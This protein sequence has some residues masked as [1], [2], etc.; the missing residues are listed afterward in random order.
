M[1]IVVM[2]YCQSSS[3]PVHPMKVSDSFACQLFE[4][5]FIYDARRTQGMYRRESLKLSRSFY[6]HILESEFLGLS[7]A[8]GGTW[9]WGRRWSERDLY[10]LG[11]I[12]LPT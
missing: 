2:L 7:S 8:I 9:H 4:R 1:H 6:I 10:L 5:P 12:A 3:I 11:P